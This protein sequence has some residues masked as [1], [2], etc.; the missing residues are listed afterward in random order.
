MSTGPTDVCKVPA[1]PAPP[2]PTPFPNIVMLAMV[3]PTSCSPKVKIEYLPVLV[4]GSEIPMS[5]GDEAGVA[6]GVVSS[7]FIG[8]CKPTLGSMKVMIGGKPVVYMT[9][10]TMHNGM[11]ANTVGQVLVAGQVRVMVMG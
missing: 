8:A 9:C 2:I 7:K 6:G 4:V 3:N 5:N 10:L 11:P 1:P